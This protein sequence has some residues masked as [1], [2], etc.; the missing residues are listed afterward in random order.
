MNKKL[1]V[2][3]RI[4][5]WNVY[6]KVQKVYCV[7]LSRDSQIEDLK[8]QYEWSIQDN[9][10]IEPTKLISRDTPECLLLEFIELRPGKKS[11]NTLSRYRVLMDECGRNT[12]LDPWFG[13]RWLF[14]SHLVFVSNGILTSE[15]SGTRNQFIIFH[16]CHCQSRNSIIKTIISKL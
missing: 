13:R 1:T 9:Y 7:N 12:S 10:F 11:M 3:D 8:C 4:E 6:F 16:V 5:G 15:I 2:N 14:S